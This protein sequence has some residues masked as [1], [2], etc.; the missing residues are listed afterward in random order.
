MGLGDADGQRAEPVVLVRLDLLA[1]DRRVLDPLGAVDRGGDLLDLLL[2]AVI[3]LVEEAEPARLVARFDDRP[4]QVGGAGAP[5][6]EVR[7]HRHSGAERLGHLADRAVLG[8]VVGREPVDRHDRRH[9]VGLDVLDLLA[10]VRRAGL[11]VVGVLGQ[12][13]LR[14]R[15]PGDDAVLARVRLE[16][17]DGRDEHGGVGRQARRAALDVEEPLGAH[18][19]AEAR[20]GDQVIAAAD[21][22]QI[23]DHGRVAGGDVAERPGMDDD[24]RVLERLQEVRGE[25][26]AHDDRHRPGGMQLLGGH[27]RPGARVAD[28]DPAQARPEV[29]HAGGEAQDRHHLGRRGDVEPGLAY[30]AVG[31]AAEADDDVAQRPVVD[32]HHASPRDVVE[33]EAELVAVVQVVVDHRRQQVVGGGHGVEVAGEVEVEQLHRDHLA[34]ATARR[35]TL[36]AERRPHRRLPQRE[37]GVLADVLHRL[38]EPHRSG[39]LALTERR[40][41]DRRDHHVLALRAVAQLVDR[42]EPDLGEVGAVRLQQVFADTHLGG[43]LRHR[44]R[45]RR[46]RDLQV[47]RECHR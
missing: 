8:R 38:A 31:L 30:D 22:D 17:A 37:H 15:T 47:G 27:R 28:D 39:R 10:E 32:V 16:G 20:L 3:V 11:D 26:V 41:R 36:D 42:V 23:A 25:R 4:G 5:V 24:R 7:A 35:P 2:Q 14:Q 18:V 12:Q 44:F 13:V 19:G 6:A 1:G 29:L 34:V 9:A 45:C 43:D 33:V 40:R 21:A 46:P